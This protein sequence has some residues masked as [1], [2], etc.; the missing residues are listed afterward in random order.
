MFYAV[1]TFCVCEQSVDTFLEAHSR[2]LTDCQKTVRTYAC[3]LL[4]CQTAP[5]ETLFY[6]SK[7]FTYIFMDCAG[8]S[9]PH[10]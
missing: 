7:H 4:S 6:L 1:I 8:T 2:F 5:L 3:K 9:L 10:L